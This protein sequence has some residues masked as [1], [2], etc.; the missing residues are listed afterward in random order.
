MF[1][2]GSTETVPSF[3]I[4]T[5]ITLESCSKWKAIDKFEMDFPFYFTEKV[6]K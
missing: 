5:D 2:K 1:Y 3:D 4:Q 6:I